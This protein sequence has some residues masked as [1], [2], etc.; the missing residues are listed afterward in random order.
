[1]NYVFIYINIFT[2]RFI[3]E[4]LGKYEVVDV[5]ESCFSLSTDDISIKND[6]FDDVS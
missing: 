1:M 6:E 4:F 3:N 2:L 5:L